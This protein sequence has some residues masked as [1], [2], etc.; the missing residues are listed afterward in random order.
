MCDN[1]RLNLWLFN[2]ETENPLF[3]YAQTFTDGRKLMFFVDIKLMFFCRR[4]KVAFDMFEI[5]SK[6]Q[7]LICHYYSSEPRVRAIFEKDGDGQKRNWNWGRRRLFP[8]QWEE[9]LSHGPFL[10]EWHSI[11]ALCIRWSRSRCKKRARQQTGT[12]D[13]P[14]QTLSMNHTR[15]KNSST[16]LPVD[17]FV[18]HN[19]I[20][21]PLLSMPQ[22]SS[23]AP[24]PSRA[25]R[26]KKKKTDPEIGKDSLVW[27]P[28]AHPCEACS[29]VCLQNAH[30]RLFLCHYDLFWI[31][32]FEAAAQNRD[33]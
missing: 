21:C 28:V 23:P 2:R 8:D 12:G 1:H 20:L 30:L 22:A 18:T 19:R 3:C 6:G 32:L 29:T 7:C 24:C 9:P 15:G 25:R 11:S 14:H 27:T 31:F 10:E 4:V 33:N 26:K 16:R 17:F 5:L 13:E